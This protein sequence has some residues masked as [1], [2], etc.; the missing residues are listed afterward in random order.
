MSD[1]HAKFIEFCVG[2]DL[3]VHPET[4]EILAI[5][6]IRKS[7]GR[8]IDYR[9]RDISAFLQK[10][11]NLLEQSNC[12]IGHNLLKFD[13]VHLIAKDSRFSKFLN[14]SIDTLW[15]SPL[16]FPLK[17]YHNLDK[18][19]LDSALNDGLKNDPEKDALLSIELLESQQKA[20]L[21]LDTGLLMAIHYLTT[22]EKDS[23][24]F[25][26]FF[27]NLRNVNTL[28]EEDS[29]T[30]IHQ[31][32]K[33]LACSSGLRRRIVEFSTPEYSWSL[34]YALSW[35]T[36]SPEN[37]ALPPWV[38][39]TF[40]KV[41]NVLHS[42]R[43]T[44]CRRT[45]CVWCSEHREPKAALKR[46]FGYE[47]FRKFPPDPDK[48][49]GS[50]QHR[51]VDEAMQGNSIIGV[52]PTGAGKSICYQ[53]PALSYYQSMGAL[54]VVIS[55]LVA[56]MTDQIAGMNE[57]EISSAITVNGNLT[58]AKRSEAL[59]K[60]RRGEISM[61][62]I[63][64]EQLR[65]NAIRAT[66]E[67][68]V[69]A[70]WV[71]DEAHCLSN[72]GHDFRTDYR[73]VSRFIDELH[74]ESI[75][76]Q[77]LCLTATAK[78]EVVR[79]IEEHFAKRLKIGFKKFNGGSSRENLTFEVQ[80]T[81]ERT[82]ETD[83]LDTINKNL[84]IDGK[85]GAI[86]YCSK[87]IHTEKLAKFLDGRGYAVARFHAGIP[88][89]EKEV[90]QDRFRN[91]EIRIVVATNAFGMGIDKPDIR[92]VVH[93]DI[94]GSLE[95]Y[96][97]ETGRAGRDG[98]NADCVLLFFDDDIED[99][100]SLK[101]KNQLTHKE[102]QAILK[103]I[104]Q[105]R[106]RKVSED[107]K[108]VATTSE[109]AR[110]HP[111]DDSSNDSGEF[112]S[113]QNTYDPSDVDNK[114]RAAV[115]WLEEAELLIRDENRIS[116]F[117]ASL[118]VT[119]RAEAERLL[120]LKLGKITLARRRELL[121]IV[122][123]LLGASVERG[124]STDDL[125]RVSGLKNSRLVKALYDL[126]SLGIMKN[127][128]AVTV[129]VNVGIKNGS[130]RNLRARI[131]IEREMISLMRESAPDVS[132]E[133]R[134]WV[135]LNLRMFAQKLSDRDIEDARPDVIKKILQG[136]A[137]DGRDRDGGEGSIRLRVLNRDVVRL[138]LGRSWK[139]LEVTAQRRTE[140][141][142]TLLDYMVGKIPVGTRGKDLAVETTLGDLFAAL[143]SNMLFKNDEEKIDKLLER[144]L[145]WMHEQDI[146]TIGDGL[147]IFRPALTLQL[148][149]GNKR[150]TKENFRPLE[151]YYREQ[152]IQIHIMAEYAK[153]GKKAVSLAEDYFKLEQNK[154]LKK[155][156][157]GKK[158]EVTLQTTV[159]KRNQIV[160]EL[161]NKTQQEIVEYDQEE[162]SML[163]LAGP[164]SGKTR[165][166]VHRIA[167]LIRVKREDPKS[168]LVLVYTRHVATEI[169]DRLRNLIDKDAF[170][171]TVKTCHGL[172]M[173]LIGKSF[174]NTSSE[175][176][177]FEEILQKATKLISDEELDSDEAEIQ[178]ESLIYGYNRI[179]V[180]EYQDIGPD[181]YSLISAIAGKNLEDKDS[182]LSLMAVGDDDQNIYSFKDA[183]VDYIRR[184]EED[185]DAKRFHLV[186]NYRSTRHIID[187]A[188][189]VISYSKE[190]MKEDL[191]IVIDLHRANEP[192]GGFLSQ[193]DPVAHGR[194]QIL[195]CPNSEK[196]QSVIAVEELKRLSN[197]DPDWDW[198]KVAIITRDW[199]DL[200]F[201]KAY[202]EHC[203]IPVT[204]AN[205][206]KLS[207]WRFRET[208]ELVDKITESRSDT[209]TVEDLREMLKPRKINRWTELLERGID[210]LQ[211]EIGDKAVTREG[212][213]EWMAEWSQD[214][215]ISQRGLLLLVAHKAKGLEFDHVVILDG[216]WH[217]RTGK[218]DDD[219]PRRLYYVAMTRARK[220]LAR[221]TSGSNLLSLRK[222]KNFLVRTV[223]S[224]TIDL[225]GI[226]KQYILPD[227]KLVY[228]SYAGSRWCHNSS[229]EAIE[230]AN[231]GDKINLVLNAKGGKWR[232]TNDRGI[233]LGEMSRKFQPPRGYKL[234]QCKIG[235][236]VTRNKSD[237]KE[238]EYR[239]RLI[240]A[241][242]EV[243][244]PEFTYERLI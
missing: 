134:D 120:D 213:K 136:W 51:I 199:K 220:S 227:M 40:P 23:T 54:T 9:H 127:D 48:V 234:V 13:L 89:E 20:F 226:D 166:L 111:K 216:E 102:I 141:V 119:N 117:P 65:S 30:A 6:A 10:L 240:R 200:R 59:D 175:Q 68:R 235:A 185:Y 228:L 182:R 86:V 43:L 211:Q 49:G 171:V 22:R 143:K 38:I 193:E 99:Q 187:A 63:S 157:S 190:R 31:S 36:V 53:I 149:P 124:V 12:L 56:L 32:L 206:D 88:K 229:L 212:A 156:F 104:R 27:K 66:L 231:V 3:E 210:S 189:R 11:E 17:T 194:V 172:A 214:V 8:K 29:L 155:W 184:F 239:N 72:W 238:T 33:G 24:G 52:L 203:K 154:F 209:L 197:L 112:D 125:L 174:I 105:L 176:R 34:A 169:K 173:Q 93:A 122:D 81:S 14:R 179:F 62:L 167:Y 19:H 191:D 135:D 242:W 223:S 177:N 152:T 133:D 71:L 150:F 109:I 91:G 60:V 208:T 138:R 130:Q 148:R 41:V 100:F 44:N 218:E 90:I 163:V 103:S 116:V 15:L 95:S 25:D 215:K 244:L 137:G 178:R 37:A 101:A 55:P 113:G 94:P 16:A 118:K 202:A 181:E 201:V 45:D 146:A 4:A 147:S 158:S 159:E 131:D 144:C 21:G 78:P 2:L 110:E 221:I 237:T 161:N 145:L 47:D 42:L 153:Q 180:D 107:D 126:E 222:N 46:Y 170:G 7:T 80:K 123:H 183:S 230:R 164:G 92:L 192:A 82:K 225:S 58:M 233:V 224:P 198:N 35:I 69:I 5:A 97:Q 195:Q 50:L 204:L 76:P 70:M 75:D 39:K 64:P 18:P 115:H 73:Y 84:P 139:S 207:I 114:V 85:S 121:T 205:E 186:D 142:S 87:R 232:I 57:R 108:L 165:V 98:E 28:D 243:I 67:H 236:I 79:D 77:I 83:I 196:D 241:K 61:L 96:V 168:I 1:I 140:G 106:K 219:A 74:Q 129:Y 160:T 151:N 132:K 128:L 26:A 217:R 162:T 188:N